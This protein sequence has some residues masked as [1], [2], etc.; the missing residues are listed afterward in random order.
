VYFLLLVYPAFCARAVV[1]VSSM[2]C[3]DPRRLPA[4]VT[5]AEDFSTVHTSW[6]WWR[7]RATMLRA[8]IDGL[9]LMT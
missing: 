6:P 8:Y 1:H 4:T 5:F 3:E 7:T 2:T 9:P